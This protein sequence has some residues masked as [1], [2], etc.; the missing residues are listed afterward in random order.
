MSF[1]FVYQRAP[2]A[3]RI[4]G[5]YTLS[6]KD[7]VTGTRFEDNI[8]AAI[9]LEEGVTVRKVRVPKVQAALRKLGMPLD[10]E[11]IV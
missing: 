6:G 11:Q 9:A 2:N 8:G 4:E 1:S 5:E 3:R 10:A 7:S